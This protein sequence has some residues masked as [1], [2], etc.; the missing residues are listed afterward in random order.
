MNRLNRVRLVLWFL[1][2]LGASVSFAAP[3]AGPRN[4]SF[5]IQGEPET[6]DW[7]RAH[8]PIETYLLMNLMEGLVTYDSEMN[9]IPALAQSWRVSPDGKTYLFKLRERVLWSDGKPLRAQDFVFSWRRLLSPMTA[10]SYAYFLFDIQGAQEFNQGTLKDF[11]GV[12]VHALS[13]DLLEVKLKR[14]VAHWIHI[15]T[16]WVTF[17][18]REDVVQKHGSTGW[19][20]PGRMVTLGPYLLASHD[21]DSR[22]VLRANPRY[23]GKRGNIDQVTALIVSDDSTALNL[24][25]SGKLDFLTDI[26]SFDLKRLTGR[27]DVRSFPY[28]KTGYLGFVV[29]QFPVSNQKVRRAISMAIDPS[30]VHEA[31]HG[32][33]HPAGSFVPPTLLA[34][35]M[36]VGLRFQ[37]QKAKQELR[38]SGLDLTRPISID[39]ILPNWERAQIVG[40]LIQ[41]Q[42]KE[43]LGIQVR[44]QPFDNK[45]FRAQVDLHT[46]PLY[47]S[48][49]SADFPDPD[50]FLS[51]FLSHSGNN[52][53]TWKNQ[54]YD[55]LVLSAREFM[56]PKKREKNYLDAQKLL[57]EDEVVLVPLYYEPNIALVRP[58]V[59]GLH[60]NSLNYLILKDVSL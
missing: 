44:L 36:S 25:E 50:N 11:N 17:P 37:P 7:N 49:W 21:L 6:L 46:F 45:M 9:I 29:S 2:A 4:F 47:L 20:T 39:L 13:D 57:Q 22:I 12:G 56:Q 28:L 51:L 30:K 38:N 41:A 53:T 14:P 54:V 32:G 16:F 60:L 52:R 15:P 42:L 43:N 24:Y 34:H 19:E 18:L 26:S 48:S 3:A 8:T 55:Q 1:T 31:L 33:Q 40:Q 10:A 58:T 59:K 35:S 23:Y 5:R 27:T